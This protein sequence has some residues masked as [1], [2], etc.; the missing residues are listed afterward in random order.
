ML[1]KQI[2]TYAQPFI[3]MYQVSCNQSNELMES[4]RS[5]VILKEF[6]IL[7]GIV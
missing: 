3:R 5:S 1:M 2:N 7:N 4:L 6:Q